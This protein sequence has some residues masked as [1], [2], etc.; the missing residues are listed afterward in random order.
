MKSKSDIQKRYSD[1][2][3]ISRYKLDGKTDWVGLLFERYTHLV[4]GVCM[5]YLKIEEESR[6]AVM[7]IFE[8]LLKDLKNY[9]IQNFKS[10][11]YT[12]TKNHCLMK[13]R[14]RDINT[15]SSEAVLNFFW[16]DLTSELDAKEKLEKN[17]HLLLNEV[18]NLPEEQQICLKLFY[19]EQKS[20]KQ[21]IE[22]TGFSDKN[23]K[24]YIQ[25]GKRRLKINLINKFDV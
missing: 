7:D 23:V 10:W 19:L 22:E 20:Y 12:Y 2:T 14:K 9:D 6:D 11:L 17:I 8:R 5:N 4:F 21:I 3:L 15:V 24:S 16:E 25:N 18:E 1:E 13:I